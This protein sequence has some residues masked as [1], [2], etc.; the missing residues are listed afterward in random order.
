MG[1]SHKIIN[2]IMEEGVEVPVWDD[3]KSRWSSARINAFHPKRDYNRWVMLQPLPPVSPCQEA[4][5][6]AGTFPHLARL[7]E[8]HWSLKL[9]DEITGP[10]RFLPSCLRC[11]GWWSPY[12][13]SHELA[14]L[15][16]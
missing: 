11:V 5:I 13:K 16:W 15:E 3:V 2:K 4:E 14:L 1:S 6:E 10:G 9:E 7:V 8:K 12:D